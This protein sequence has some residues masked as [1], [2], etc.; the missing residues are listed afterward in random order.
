MNGQTPEWLHTMGLDCVASTAREIQRRYRNRTRLSGVLQRAFPPQM[1]RLSGVLRSAF[2][3]P[4]TR[5]SGVLQPA[6]PSPMTR[7][8]G[9]RTAQF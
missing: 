9:G 4:M 1:T 8:S 5:L 6:F 3:P 7:L 2:P